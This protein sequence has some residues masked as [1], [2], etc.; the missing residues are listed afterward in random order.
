MK[1]E[2][3]NTVDADEV[4]LWLKSHDRTYF[5]KEKNG[6]GKNVLNTQDPKQDVR[7]DLGVSEKEEQPWCVNLSKW[8][9]R[10]LASQA[11][12]EKQ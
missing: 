11:N 10:A 8:S 7:H 2:V 3:S 9:T 1:Q 12:Q 6:G 5:S 4:Y